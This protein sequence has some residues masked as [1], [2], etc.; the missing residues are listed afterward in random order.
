[1]YALKRVL[2]FATLHIFNSHTFSTWCVVL[3]KEGAFFFVFF[4]WRRHFNTVK[5]FNYVLPCIYVFTVLGIAFAQL[6][7][8]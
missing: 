6:S 2:I 5:L 8:S 3:F 7:S 4:F 1:M